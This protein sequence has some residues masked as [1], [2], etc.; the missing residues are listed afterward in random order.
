MLRF[1]AFAMAATLAATPAFAQQK[2]PEPA[3]TG[4][5]IVVIGMS[6]KDA[7]AALA[8][9]IAQHCPPD[10]DVDATLAVAETQFVAG[11]YKNARATM[12]KSIGRNKRFANAYPVPVSDLLRANSRV[13]AH[14]GEQDAY[15]GGALDVI[16]ALKSGLPADDWR[17][18][19]AQVELGDAYA[20]TGRL[21]AGVELY[22]KVARRARELKQP[23][24]EGY[25]LLR[26]AMV[27]AAA[28]DRRDDMNFT[29]AIAASNALIA[30]S[31]PALAP[32]VRSAKLLKLKLAVRS[33]DAG[34]IDRLVA[35]YQVGTVSTPVLLYAPKIQL[36]ER[37]IRPDQ[38]G[39]TLNR[40]LLDDVDNQWVDISFEVLPD[41]KVGEPEVLRKSEKLSGDWVKPILTAL[42]GRRYAPL[43]ANSDSAFRVERYTFTAPWT[44]V[45][46]TRMR[47][48]SPVPTIE[49]IDLSRD[50]AVMP[51][52]TPATTPGTTPAPTAAS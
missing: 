40:I 20:K 14:L 31:D 23:R 29:A 30:N 50:P 34:A 5:D 33:G 44:T 37:A 4:P 35:E 16:S 12:L 9:C 47:V 38:G 41:G 8:A 13:S 19:G 51:V 39:E 22:R 52:A 2:A 26:V 15:F 48:R 6:L 32:F 17:V 45:T 43:A 36:P 3:A 24:V 42:G 46:G 1:K 21:A 10:K 18:L 49:A 7:K 11:D 25:A 27:Y 28:S